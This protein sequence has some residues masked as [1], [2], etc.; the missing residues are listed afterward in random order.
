MNLVGEYV[1]HNK[2]GKGVVALV[3][4]EKIEVEFDDL[5]IKKFLYPDVFRRFMRIED[6]VYQEYVD[7]MLDE[8]D[9][10][11]NIRLQE[12]AREMEHLERARTLK[13]SNNS[14]A[15]FAFID[16]SVEETVNTWSVFTGTYISGAS[17]GEPRIPQ[18]LNINSACLLTMKPEGVSEE[19]RIIIG[20]FM[21]P[22]NFKSSLCKD[23]IINAHENYRIML[24]TEKEKLLFWDYCATKPKSMNWGKCEF[25][26]FSNT[27]MQNILLDMTKIIKDEDRCKKALEFYEYFCSINKIAA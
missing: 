27:E 26:Y 24:D 14:Q 4:E 1:N 13:V 3:E 19:E 25:K 2:F 8:M 12:E 15:V 16:N 9:K 6:K 10:E 22:D 21:V 18:R 11:N 17:K 5:G 23:G 20:A 7:E